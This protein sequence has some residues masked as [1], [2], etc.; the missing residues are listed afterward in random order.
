MATSMLEARNLP[1][2]LWAEVVNGDF[3]IQ[4]RAPHKSVVGVTPF[5][6]LMEHKP[7]V[8]HLRVFGSKAWTI[9]PY[10][11]RKYLQPQSSECILLGYEKDAKVY[12]LMDIATRICFIERSV[13]FIEDPL[14]DLQPVEEEGIF[15]LRTSFT[16]D[17]D[18]NDSFSDDSYSKFEDE[19]QV[20]P[21]LDV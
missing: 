4:N 10:D 1:P 19:D 5:K 21:D 7:N 18:H 11:K 17:E 13:H 8:S 12:K 14:Q 16:H 3:Y 20:E 15:D 9:I 6:A 2:Y